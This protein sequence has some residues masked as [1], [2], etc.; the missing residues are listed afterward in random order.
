V[1]TT[2]SPCWFYER[3]CQEKYFSAEL[4]PGENSS[5][6]SAPPA[7]SAVRCNVLMRDRLRPVRDNA[8]KADHW[9]VE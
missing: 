8:E 5:W 7:R 3:K 1:T 2:V 9:E 6:H 4:K